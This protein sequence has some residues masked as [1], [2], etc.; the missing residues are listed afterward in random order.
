MELSVKQ[1]IEILMMIGYGDRS[2]TQMEVCNLFN[3]K[4]PERPI[5]RS[6]VSKLETKFLE[7]GT[8]A[9]LR[10]SGRPPANAD[11]ALD[12]LLSF[13][14][15]AHTSVRKVSREIGVGK[16]TVHKLLK[17][18]KW[19][20]YK[21]KLVQELNEDDPDR[22]L[23]F[24]EEMMDKCHRDP[25][26]I[27]NI[28]FSDESTFTLTG[29]VNR[30]NCRYWA[31][32]NPH[33]MREH[34][35]QYPQKVNVWAG[36][37]RNRIIGPY[38]IEGDLNGA[39][40]LDFLRGYLVPTLRNLFPSRRNPGGFDESLWFQ[41]DGAPPHYAVDVRM[42]VDEIFPNRW[43]GRRGPTE[44]PAR[45]PDLNPLDYFLWGHL[46]NV[47]Y[48]T[49]PA[50]IEDVQVKIQT[51]IN[52]ITQE[53]IHKVQQEFVHRLGYCQIQQGLQFDHLI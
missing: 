45:S 5:T 15:D 51:E 19:H 1:R 7:T 17:L 40:Y 14:E 30:Q 44:W 27:Q 53:T 12:V 50:N 52:N 34:H 10:K 18:E 46:K 38:F 41:Q 43:I 31:K 20:P 32:E 33:W 13:Q 16:T 2:R 4:Y 11:T 35:T 37:V 23:Q 48:K 6:T 9:N 42:Y 47:I 8:V 39:K 28:I 24:C 3:D 21:I 49:K 29:E 22:R 25:L 26:L 36:I